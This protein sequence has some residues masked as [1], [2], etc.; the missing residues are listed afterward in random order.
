M[1]SIFRIYR[2]NKHYIDKP[3]NKI[4]SKISKNFITFHNFPYNFPLYSIQYQ[5]IR[6]RRGTKEKR[7]QELVES[8]NK[9]EKGFTIDSE[10]VR[11]KM[12]LHISKFQSKIID[13]VP[14]SFDIKSIENIEVQI[15]Q[16]QKGKLKKLA[17]INVRNSTT[18]II[19]SHENENI[20]NIVKALSIHN[21]EF[22][23]R[24]ESSGLI[25]VNI[26][27]P[28]K[29]EIE[30]LKGAVKVRYDNCIIE[31]KQAH[32]VGLNDLKKIEEHCPK[33]DAFQYT[34]E[35][36]R[37]VKEQIDVATRIFQRKMKEF[38]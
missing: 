16:N 25:Y 4:L 36:N 19:L 11:N 14:K 9:P 33:D 13:I 23:P 7:K 17:D 27:Q 28:K 31:L 18:C 26:P 12:Q 30:K 20:E 24:I 1:S 32:K 21:S 2:L 37:L 15:K 8:G 5:S 3:C 6:Y 34:N 22:D 29:D 35:L 38:Q 10:N